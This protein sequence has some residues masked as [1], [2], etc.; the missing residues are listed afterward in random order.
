MT[1]HLSSQEFVNALDRALAPARQSHLEKCASCQA[2]V[3]ELCDVL[4]YAGRDSALGADMP[5]PSPPDDPGVDP[6][7]VP[8]PDPKGP[9]TTAR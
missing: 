5:E 7:V 1:N 9:E 3:Q 2:Q 6:P 4:E 8:Q